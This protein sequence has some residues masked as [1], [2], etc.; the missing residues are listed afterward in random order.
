MNCNDCGFDAPPLT[1]ATLKRGSTVREPGEFLCHSCGAKRVKL[2]RDLALLPDTLPDIQAL[3]HRKFRT[4]LR[5][6]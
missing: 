3:K 1:D 6:I 2:V 5:S 4:S